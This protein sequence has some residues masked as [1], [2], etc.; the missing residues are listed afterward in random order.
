MLCATVVATGHALALPLMP[1]F[2]APKDGA[3]KQDCER[4]AVKR[5]LARHAVA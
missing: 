5:W 4:S 2:I 1:Q 3:E